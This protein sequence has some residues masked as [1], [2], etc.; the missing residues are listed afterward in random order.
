MARWMINCREHSRLTSESMDHSLCFWDRLSV[1]IHQLICPPCNQL[2][3]QFDAIRKACRLI[4]SESEDAGGGK[5]DV[6]VLP[7]D[8]CQRM[9]SVL[10][11]HLK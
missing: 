10:R 6:A 11:A 2:R 8:V 5:K 3:Q 1:R 7:E 4:P 9:K